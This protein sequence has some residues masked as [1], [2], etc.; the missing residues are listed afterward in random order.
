MATKKKISKKKTSKKAARRKPVMKKKLTPKQ[1]RFYQ[2]YIETGNA[3]KSYRQSYDCERMKP[4]TI[5]R[6]AKDLL[7]N[8]K[9][10]ARLK[11]LR[12]EHQERHNITIDS[13]TQELE[14][15]RKLAM[16]KGNPAG[17]VSAINAKAKL[18]GLLMKEKSPPIRIGILKGSL[19]KQGQQIISA[20][21]KGE[22]SPPDASSMLQA[23]A[24]QVK[25]I[26]ADE[27]DKRVTKLEGK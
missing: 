27:L 2:L 19:T 18:H 12:S 23:L 14:V 15:A 13:L 7:D 20:M 6:T 16:K 17:A 24:A 9:I 5:N 21:S 4:E 3:S 8:R 26:E 11:E 22:L 25:I 10:T 1:E